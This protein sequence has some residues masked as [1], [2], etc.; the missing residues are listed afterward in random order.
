MRPPRGAIRLRQVSCPKCK[1][2]LT[3]V[4]AKA[5]IPYC[6]HCGAR[7]PLGL[8]WAWMGLGVVGAFI[9][10]L[11]FMRVRNASKKRSDENP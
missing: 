2:S 8:H 5:G 4:P 10:W 11:V 6:P 3:I 9:E 7:N 1:A